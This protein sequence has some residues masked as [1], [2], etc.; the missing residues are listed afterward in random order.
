MHIL[1]RLL[2]TLQ[3][4]ERSVAKAAYL[5]IDIKNDAEPAGAE[6]STRCC[7]GIGDITGHARRSEHDVIL[8]AR[9]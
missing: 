3:S 5:R 4:I 8:C 6:S 2:E 1:S 9:Y 7:E